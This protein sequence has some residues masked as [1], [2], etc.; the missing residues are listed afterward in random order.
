MPTLRPTRRR[1]AVAVFAAFMLI[2]VFA[3]V[4]FSIDIGTILVAKSELQNAADAA[5]IAGAWE[6]M[7]ENAL[8][9]G[10]AQW[11]L[12]DQAIEGAE[13]FVSFN[14]VLTD[15]VSA[16]TGNVTVGFIPNP[17]DRNSPFVTGSGNAANAV[18]VR[19]FCNSNY[20]SPVNMVFARVLGIQKTDVEATATA[21][22]LS[23]INGVSTPPSGGNLGMLPYALDEDTWLDLL[24][25]ATSDD[26]EW[27]AAAGEISS[28][29]DGIFEA[30]LFPQGT[31]SPGNRGTVDIGSNNNSTA[32]IARQIV[33]GISP[34]DL[35]Y[36][37]GKLEFD[38]DG[39]MYLNGDTGISAG[40]KDE[41]ES[42]KG[43]PR[44]IPIFRS[45]SGP[46]NNA[47]YTIVKL[48]GVRILEVKLT[49]KMSDKRVVIQPANVAISGG[50]PGTNNTTSSFIYTPAWLV[51]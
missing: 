3:F 51:R 25:N 26:W 35:S 32:D 17:L 12:E 8:N 41:L 22:I 36:H 2:G 43:Q 7:D 38:T 40:V 39:K 34:A 37:G 47:T 49:G 21:A 44:I 5:A 30:N 9:G 46:G 16:G 6:L 24:S 10:T 4:A 48:V 27:D 1:G 13:E 45:V 33:Y 31:G 19:L 29:S 14:Q 20:N 23:S 50:I 15:S 42:I 28:G 18:E 11:L